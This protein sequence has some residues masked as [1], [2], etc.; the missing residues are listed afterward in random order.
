MPR[1]KPL[2]FDLIRV[3]SNLNIRQYQ[4]IKYAAGLISVGL[5]ELSDGLVQFLNINDYKAVALYE[6]RI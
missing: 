5:I 2:T 6:M 3:Q 4:E 1:F